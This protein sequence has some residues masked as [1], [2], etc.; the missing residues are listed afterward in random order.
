M[1]TYLPMIR[2]SAKW[3]HNKHN[4]PQVEVI[5]CTD[6][7]QYRVPSTNGN[8]TVGAKCTINVASHRMD[9]I[10]CADEMIGRFSYRNPPQ[11]NPDTIIQLMKEE[12][13]GS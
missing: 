7:Y 6:G 4:Y 8:L 10:L 11:V 9:V 12:C 1:Q 13:Y 5:A 3:S 2:E